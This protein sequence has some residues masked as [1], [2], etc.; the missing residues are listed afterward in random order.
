MVA[1]IN[2]EI[3]TGEWLRTTLDGIPNLGAI[4]PAGVWRDQ[5]PE[6]KDLPG[7]R[8]QVQSRHDVN[9]GTRSSQRIM[10]EIDWLVVGTV[11]GSSLVPLVAIA[12]A[13]DVALQGQSGST[14]AV[15][16]LSCL[17]QQTFFM[18][19]EGRSG[20]LFR[21]SGGIYRTLVTPL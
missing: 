15:S 2:E 8:Y 21:H 3:H 10:V 18:T 13:I 14:A 12:D 16:V 20:V 5:I 6:D 1:K 4:A 7:I 11:S 17:R 9:G 19:E